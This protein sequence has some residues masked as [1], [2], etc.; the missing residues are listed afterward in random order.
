MVISLLLLGQH[1]FPE[2]GVIGIVVTVTVVMTAYTCSMTGRVDQSMALASRSESL[3]LRFTI[4]SIR[5]CTVEQSMALTRKEFSDYRYHY[6]CRRTS[7]VAQSM[8]FTRKGT[9]EPGPPFSLWIIS[10]L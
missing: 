1:K 2:Y 8:E 9:L 10:L 3:L 5:T 6:T 4:L 7:T